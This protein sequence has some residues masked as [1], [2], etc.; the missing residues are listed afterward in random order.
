MIEQKIPF[1]VS[2][3]TARLIGRENVASAEGAIIE[4][5]KNAYDAD[6]KCCLIYFDVPYLQA[7][8]EISESELHDLLAVRPF[9]GMDIER[10]FKRQLAFDKLVFD[11][12]GHTEKER[13]KTK[14]KID[15][16][17]R[18]FSSIIILDNGTGMTE[19]I[20]RS[21]WMTIGTNDKQA[22]F[23]SPS[24]RVKSGE[25]GIGRFALDRLGSRSTLFT[26]RDDSSLSWSVDWE[27]FSEEG[28]HITEIN[29]TL[30]TDIPS[31]KNLI[32]TLVTAGKNHGSI[33]TDLS[34]NETDIKV[35]NFYDTATSGTILKIEQPR[36]NWTPESIRSLTTD[37]E[38]LIPPKE[39]TSFQI[40]VFD[41]QDPS[42][43]SLVQT[44]I[45][46]D[47]DYKLT[48]ECDEQM[49]FSMEIERNEYDF[50]KI[51]SNFF[52][53]GDT[54]D[55][56][57]DLTREKL[58]FSKSLG[59]LVPGTSG[60]ENI[61][62]KKIGA[63]RISL[64]FL[65][66]SDQQANRDKYFHKDREQGFYRNRKEWLTHN[67]GIKVF[68][69]NFRVRPYGEI[70]G[71]AWDWLGLG[72]RVARDPAPA[73]RSERWKVSPTN[74]AGVIEISRTANLELKDKSSREGFVDSPY[75]GAFKEIIR[76]LIK[77][78]EDDRSRI[79]SEFH[80]F[81]E[82]Q[83]AIP[84]EEDISKQDKENAL[85]LA[86]DI[87]ED[88][89]NRNDMDGA[90]SKEEKIAFALL[91]FKNESDEAKEEAQEMK[92]EN[93]LM[94]VFASSGITISSFAHELHNLE[95]KLGNRFERIVNLYSPFVDEEALS[96][97]IE[98]KN[99]VKR[100]K[101]IDEED[102][103][104]KQWLMYALDVIR[105]DKRQRKKVYLNKYLQLFVGRWTNLLAS[106]NIEIN[107]TDRNEKYSMRCFEIDLDC[108]FNN[109]IINSVEFFE[110]K[111]TTRR[112][113]RI[114]IQEQ[115]GDNNGL[116]LSYLD[117][118]P[119]LSR[120]ITDPDDIFKPAFTT[121]RNS[122]GKAI[123]TGLGM[124]L[125]KKTI[126]EY[127]NASIMLDTNHSGFKV[128]IYFPNVIKEVL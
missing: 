117:F 43:N 9:V 18:S 15:S 32:K 2:A 13:K 60:N 35:R 31:L 101:L 25:K 127:N 27:S 81:H 124:W 119:G 66:M 62:I 8:E 106:K 1:N 52:E 121:K 70:D 37:L 115:K 120:D 57:T 99:P 72:D 38:S 67:S 42:R 97:V 126:E 19:N 88:F 21:H 24:G 84:S 111:R 41:A 85:S 5:V 26:S 79:H 118:G 98:R 10:Y 90:K 59:E 110:N 68:R 22:N 96:N 45:Y 55:E 7:P 49:D 125:V 109:L 40:Y 61:D 77:C 39:D 123:G 33:K 53:S 91:N 29:A 116:S 78:F 73:H 104:L 6:A 34:E 56:K 3:R 92:E 65:K 58:K 107:F 71:P 76:I 20:I 108:I 103:K 50:K 36:D 11:L 95:S 122:S 69:D 86:R 63:F 114:I 30:Q 113:I 74:I 93:A 46:E 47:F 82:K 94:R 48:A 16:Y 23:I 83:K 100:L 105:K 64:Y 89:K 12:S 28:K 4:L 44:K 102:K 54:E 75:L 112:E 128:D 80:K 17:F 51:P 87:F 14:D